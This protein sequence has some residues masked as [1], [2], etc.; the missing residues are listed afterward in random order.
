[1]AKIQGNDIGFAWNEWES[2]FRGVVGEMT[3]EEWGLSLIHI[4]HTCRYVMDSYLLQAH[5]VANRTYCH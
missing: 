3:D 1:M 2:E 4:C 5:T